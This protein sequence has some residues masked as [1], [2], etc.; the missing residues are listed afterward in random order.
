MAAKPNSLLPSGDDS[1]EE[2]EAADSGEKRLLQR[3]NG[4]RLPHHQH[5]EE[6]QT[7]NEQVR[8]CCHEFCIPFLAQ[9]LANSVKQRRQPSLVYYQS[10]HKEKQ[11][12]TLSETPSQGLIYC[13]LAYQ[14][15]HF[16]DPGVREC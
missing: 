1:W 12:C 16:Y 11:R 13:I 3:L 2:G 9:Q 8:P 5:T 10:R 14:R 15:V 6:Q 4:I 7:T